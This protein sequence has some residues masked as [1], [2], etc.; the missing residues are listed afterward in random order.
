M[1]NKK[2]DT[3]YLVEAK[4]KELK[5]DSSCGS[6]WETIYTQFLIAV[7]VI[8][9]ESNLTERDKYELLSFLGCSDFKKDTVLRKE[10][11]DQ[12]KDINSLSIQKLK[13]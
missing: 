5:L 2:F 11:N 12:L 8:L 13:K 9:E 6:V 1:F 4:A 3:G 7:E 10:I